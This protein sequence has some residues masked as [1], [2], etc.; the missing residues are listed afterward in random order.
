MKACHICSG[1]TKFSCVRCR[2]SV[3]NVCAEPAD[4]NDEGYDEKIYCVGICTA[5]NVQQKN[6]QP[7]QSSIRFLQKSRKENVNVKVHRY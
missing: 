7:G 3:C 4:V 5:E 2:S 6:I 1:E